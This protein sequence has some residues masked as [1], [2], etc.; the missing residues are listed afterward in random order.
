M[1]GTWKGKVTT[2]DRIVILEDEVI[3]NQLVLLVL[4]TLLFLSFDG[5]RGE[6]E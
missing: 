4:I 6:D 1:V 3:W 2:P 5:K